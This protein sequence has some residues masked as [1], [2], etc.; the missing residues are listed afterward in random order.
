M[1]VSTW[2]CSGGYDM[3]FDSVVA[4]RRPESLNCG[5]Y[6]AV[7]SQCQ[8]PLTEGVLASSL[9]RLSKQTRAP[10][11]D[12]LSPRAGHLQLGHGRS[13]IGDSDRPHAG[14]T[15]P[16]PCVPRHFDGRR[17]WAGTTAIPL[18]LPA[19]YR[20][21]STGESPVRSCH[22]WSRASSRLTT[23]PCFPRPNRFSV[24][25]GSSCRL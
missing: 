3:A 18:V 6:S 25:P 23:D 2:S 4:T 1:L 15:V 22:C 20:S 12:G 19:S 9:P 7:L 16:V 10:G 14:H 13:M 21:D 5:Q 8:Y 11:F 24:S 17:I